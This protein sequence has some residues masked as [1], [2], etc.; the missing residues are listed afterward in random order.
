MNTPLFNA[1]V[2]L[3]HLLYYTWN[4]FPQVGSSYKGFQ[5]V[6]SYSLNDKI[7][8]FEL[9]FSLGFGFKIVTIYIKEE[10]I[11]DI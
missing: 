10:V 4:G 3:S 6:I 9:L 2:Y 5:I 1:L 7:V 8:M 11:Y